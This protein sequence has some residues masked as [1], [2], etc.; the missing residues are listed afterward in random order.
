M[1]TKP[2]NPVIL[3]ER[4]AGEVLLIKFVDGR[5]YRLQHPGNRAKLQWDRE[6]FSLTEGLDREKFLDLCFEHVVFP[7]DHDQKP[8]L[9]RLKPNEMEVWG[10][11]LPKFLRG[12]LNLLIVDA[13]KNNSPETGGE[14]EPDS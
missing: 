2:K 14:Q 11:I 8:D 6:C 3:E 10:E 1:T 5:K 13:A 4:N 9:D 12:E 7:E